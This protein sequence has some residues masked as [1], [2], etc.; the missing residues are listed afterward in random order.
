MRDAIA[1]LPKGEAAVRQVLPQKFPWS[2][3]T[4]AW[5][6]MLA[7]VLDKG[8]FKQGS[9]I[10]VKFTLTGA[11]AGVK[12]LPATL[13]VRRLTTVGGTGEATAVSTSAATT[14]NL[15]RYTDGQYLFNLN[16]KPLAVG[17][18]ELRIDLG[19]GVAHTVTITLR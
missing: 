10:P 1:A 14:G 19:D 9:T 6:M 16:T 15:F 4:L 12:N 18:Y 2:V 17:S 7:P 8:V 3:F 13:W 11:S 5:G